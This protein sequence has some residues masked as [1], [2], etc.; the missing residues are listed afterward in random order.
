MAEPYLE[1]G[2][3]DIKWTN[4]AY[5][6]LTSGA[7]V[8]TITGMGPDQTVHAIGSCPRCEHDVA[9]TRVES[10]TVPE[11]HHGLGDK[12]LRADPAL[13]EAWVP[14][15]VLCWCE[16]EHSGRPA[17][18]RGCGIAFRAEVRIDVS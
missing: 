10:I 18:V 14:V 16:D 15:D 5:D 3:N 17:K 12:G 4:D 6:L 1:T 7:L 11:G 8:V 9:Y 13:D 2:R